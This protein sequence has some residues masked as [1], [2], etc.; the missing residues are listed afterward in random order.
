[1]SCDS[2]TCRSEHIF[3]ELQNSVQIPSSDQHFAKD[4]KQKTISFS[5]KTPARIQHYMKTTSKRTLNL[6]T[7]EKAHFLCEKKL[8]GKT[9]NE[10]F[11]KNQLCTELSIN[12]TQL[13][14]WI[15]RKLL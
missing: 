15:V 9:H 6:Q 7:H 12:G 14:K 8:I 13:C 10:Q 11:D 2:D 1:M 4:N 3:N 5:Q